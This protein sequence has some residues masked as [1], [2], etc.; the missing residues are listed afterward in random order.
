MMKLMIT[1]AYNSKKKRDVLDST[2]ETIP[3]A[4]AAVQTATLKKR[5]ASFSPVTTTSDA[6]AADVTN[7]ATSIGAADYSFA[8]FASMLVNATKVATSAVAVATGNASALSS[9]GNYISLHDTTGQA[10]LA[11]HDDGNLY[12]T[13]YPGAAPGAAFLST[14]SIVTNDEQGRSFHYYPATMGAYNVSR[15][16]MSNTAEAPNGAQLLTLVPVSSGVGTI[17]SAIDTQGNVFLLAWCNAPG[18]SGAKVFLMNAGA[19]GPAILK[20]REVQ[21]VVTGDEV[22]LCA[23]LLLTSEE[24]PII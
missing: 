9:T 10:Q 14:S 20:S 4:P 11:A 12:L 18:Y 19:D 1:S 16:R 21:W 6:A 5:T 2:L 17:Y 22:S 13:S 23:P 15:I 7:A 24:E 8:P 3:S